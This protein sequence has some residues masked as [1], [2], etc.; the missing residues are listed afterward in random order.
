MM[1]E[2]EYFFK[3][4][5]AEKVIKLTS[6]FDS[7][8]TFKLFSRNIDVYIMAPI[9]G[10]LYN[11]KADIDKSNNEVTKIFPQQ[12]TNESLNLKYNYQLIMLMDKNNE[13]SINKRMDKAFRDYGSKNSEIDEKLYEQYVLGGVDVLYEKLIQSSTSPED[14]VSKLYEFLE[15]FHE[16]Y[17]ENVSNDTIMELCKLAR[18]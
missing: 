2:K 17:N 3:G 12:L 4:T 7:N 1:F 15:E 13:S 14:F 16:R 5:H 9:I 10:F 11:R 18:S 8:S 6:Q